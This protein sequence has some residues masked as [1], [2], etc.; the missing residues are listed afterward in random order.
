MKKF[1][2]IMKQLKWVK[3]F[4]E[5]PLWYI[6]YS[7]QATYLCK[8]SINKDYELFGDFNTLNEDIVKTRL[9][10]YCGM[11]FKLKDKKWIIPMFASDYFYNEANIEK[12]L[13]YAKLA[14][15]INP[16]LTYKQFG[17]HFNEE[18]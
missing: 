9:N 11:F 12:Q 4:E 3:P 14:I 1:D 5:V 13:E 10:S 18:L 2:V 7:K 15:K 6:K 16:K 17:T 8:F